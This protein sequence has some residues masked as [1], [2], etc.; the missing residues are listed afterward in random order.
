MPYQNLEDG[1]YLL[2]QPSQKGGIEHYGVL[3]IGNVLR[4]PGVS[5]IRPIVIHQT[6]PQVRPDLLENTGQWQILGQVTP[7]H[8]NAAIERCYMA[9][10]DPHYDLFE[11]NC[12]QFARYIIEGQKYSTQLIG[13]GATAVLIILGLFGDGKKL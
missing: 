9:L 2:K 10:N 1:L 13:F 11:N 12:E 8:L 3:D 4:F 7:E 5:T 6:P